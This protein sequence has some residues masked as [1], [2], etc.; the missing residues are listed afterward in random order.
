MYY[1]NNQLKL[2]ENNLKNLKSKYMQP[3]IDF[4]EQ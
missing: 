2:A 1:N 3:N 4:S